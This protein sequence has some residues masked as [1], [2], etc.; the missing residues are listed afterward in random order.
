[1]NLQKIIKENGLKL[2][3]DKGETVVVCEKAV[4]KN[5]VDYMWFMIEDTLSSVKVNAFIVI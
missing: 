3:N 2:K 5:I 1:L 4:A